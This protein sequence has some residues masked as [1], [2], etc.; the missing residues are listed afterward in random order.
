MGIGTVKPQFGVLLTRGR[1]A[2]ALR[3]SHIISSGTFVDLW[4]SPF[5]SEWTDHE[6]TASAED[7]KYAVRSSQTLSP[8]TKPF[9]PP[10]LTRF[11]V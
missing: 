3:T 9:L 2:G 1:T 4:N 10:V 6:L 8:S 5:P 7:G 11:H